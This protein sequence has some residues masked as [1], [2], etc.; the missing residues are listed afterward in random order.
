M[1]AR[2]LSPIEES[3]GIVGVVWM[4]C[5][6]DALPKKYDTFHFLPQ[7]TRSIVHQIIPADKSISPA[8]IDFILITSVVSFAAGPLDAKHTADLIYQGWRR[9]IEANKNWPD[10]PDAV[11]LWMAKVSLGEPAWMASWARS[12]AQKRD[13]NVFKC[14]FAQIYA[15]GWI[16]RSPVPPEVEQEDE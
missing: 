16:I 11:G 4:D 13:G 6:F 2:I 7:G 8:D 1:R 9:E 12:V 3:I 14:N 5:D 10:N 15:G